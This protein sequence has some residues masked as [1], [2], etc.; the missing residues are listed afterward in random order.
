MT[1]DEDFKHLKIQ[2]C[3]LKVNIHCDGCKQ[4]VKKI[5]QRI[6]GVYQV[7]IDDEQQ[8]VSVAGSVEAPTLIKKLVRAGKHAELWG[9]QKG[10]QNQKQKPSNGNDSKNNSNQNQNSAQKQQ[11]KLMKDLE[12][13][14]SQQGNKFPFLQELEYEMG[15]D[16]EEEFE[17]GEEEFRF[18]NSK[19]AQQQQQLA[20]LRQQTAEVNNAKN[21]AG[22]N[23]GVRLNNGN[24]GN[25]KSGISI[26]NQNVGMKGNSPGGIDEKTM[27]ALRMNLGGEGGKIGGNDINAMMNLAGFHGNNGGNNVNPTV[28]LPQG[29]N[30]NPTSGFHHQLLQPNQTNLIQGQNGNSPLQGQNGNFPP[31]LAHHN[32]MNM[33][34]Y[35]LHHPQASVM[36][37]MQN[38]HA[39]MQ[40]AQM[41]YNR[42]PFI[43]PSTGYYHYNNYGQSPVPPYPTYVDHPSTADHS[44]TH[45][46]SDENPSSC[47]VM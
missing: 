44:A 33:N 28:L 34:G 19:F 47:S 6:E 37:N 18:L 7:S 43:P 2:T 26:P 46:F 23:G 12:A 24:C 21:L 39:A 30:P 41:M 36:M 22:G 40:Q 8:K 5:L 1:K 3:V 13:L 14:K 9:S 4:K 25:K 29:N 35:P 10:T 31:S 20:L 17:C 38:R 32:L 15:E 42:S 45:M 27:A 16:E 11:Q